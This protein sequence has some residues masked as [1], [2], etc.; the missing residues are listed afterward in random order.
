MVE[1]YVEMTPPKSTAQMKGVSWDHRRFFEK[2]QARDARLSLVEA[3]AP[4]AP[5]EPM[6]GPV[7]VWTS[8]IFPNIKADKGI[9]VPHPQKPDIDNMLKAFLDVLSGLGYWTDD[10]QVIRLTAEKWRGPKTGIALRI[11]EFSTE[12]ACGE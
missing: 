7:E 8:W 11:A 1:L 10:K 6:Q 9:L 4:H 12:T 5:A 3:F 2:K